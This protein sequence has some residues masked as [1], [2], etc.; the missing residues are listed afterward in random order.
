MRIANSAVTGGMALAFVAVNLGAASIPPNATGTP[1]QMVVTVM[2]G[3]GGSRPA[4]LA[5]ADLSVVE[6]KAPAHVVRL[7]RLSGDMGHM[8]LYVLM[9]DSTRSASLGTHIPELKTFLESLP[10]TTDVAIGYMRNGTA[11]LAQS[12]T[13]DHHEAAS[14]IRLPEAMPGENGSPYFA[15]GDLVKHWPSQAASRRAVLMLTDGVDRY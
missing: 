11:V 14:H 10:Q 12:F 6:D 13:T 9:D 4:N 2:P 7:E 8:Q 1:A 3:A 5:A 15:L